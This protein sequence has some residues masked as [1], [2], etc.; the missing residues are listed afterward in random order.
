MLTMILYDEGVHEGDMRLWK[1]RNLT[2]LYEVFLIGNM[3]P[4]CN[5]P[6]LTGMMP[7]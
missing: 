3:L 6:Q 5:G 2:V 1:K 4:S 7:W